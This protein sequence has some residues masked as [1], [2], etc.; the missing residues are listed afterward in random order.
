[1]T[2]IRM[3][4]TAA[5]RMEH[6]RS[7]LP[8]ASNVRDGEW[9]LIEPLLPPPKRR[10]RKR[11]LSMCEVLNTILYLLKTGCRWRALP[12]AEGFVSRSSAQRYLRAWRESGLFAQINAVLREFDRFLSGRAPHPSAIIID[13]QSV[14]SSESGSLRGFDSAKR[15]WG[16]KRQ[17]HA[18]DTAGRLVDLHLTPANVQDVHAA[19][20]LLGGL[21][22]RLPDTRHVFAD[23]VYRGEA[24]L[25]AVNTEDAGKPW[26][27]EIVS[28]S[29]SIG[30]FKA[31]PK[32]WKIERTF[33]C[34]GRNRRLAKDRERK[35]QSRATF[36]IACNSSRSR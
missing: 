22:N 7:D 24:L 18:T 33:A 9:I 26:T 27:I 31:E 12:R 15:V 35:R 1:M 6:D 3:P 17:I 11:T 8:Y 19:V 34:F 10:G 21:A 20:P 29:Q 16:C 30:T 14:K 2:E 28:R 23:R 25:R 5:T 32:R 13:S 36:P 4:W